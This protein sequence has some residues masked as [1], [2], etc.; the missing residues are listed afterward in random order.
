MKDFYQNKSYEWYSMTLM[1]LSIVKN[2]IQYSFLNENMFYIQ[3]IFNE[4]MKL[5]ERAVLFDKIS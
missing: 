1:L 5:I 2:K 3:K 4:K